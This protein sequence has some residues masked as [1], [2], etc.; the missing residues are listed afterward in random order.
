MKNYT[1][2]ENTVKKTK[3]TSNAIISI[4]SSLLI[5][6]GVGTT[7]AFAHSAVSETEASVKTLKAPTMNELTTLVDGNV[8]CLENIFIYNYLPFDTEPISDGHIYEVKSDE[9]S[10]YSELEEY[11]NS[12]YTD[13]TAESVMNYPCDNGKYLDFNGKLCIDSNY[14]CDGEINMLDWTDYD[15]SNVNTYEDNCTF[16]VN[17]SIE[18]INMNMKDCTVTFNAINEDDGWRLDGIYGINTTTE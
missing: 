5:V 18:D 9:F 10:T 2:K 16:D 1:N 13:D 6:A 7:I 17:I 12:I 14:I 4:A 8:N 11:V 3:A 15:I